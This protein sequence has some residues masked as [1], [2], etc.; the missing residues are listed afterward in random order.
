[1]SNKLSHVSQQRVRESESSEYKKH[2]TNKLV[3]RENDADVDLIV[4]LDNN[5]PFCSLNEPPKNY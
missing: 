1:M 4:Q 2:K 3:S 5:K